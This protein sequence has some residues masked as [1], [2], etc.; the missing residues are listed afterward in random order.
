MHHEEQFCEIILNLAQW[1]RRI[2]HLKD[3]FYGALAVLQ[4]G[5]A[6]NIIAILRES[7]M[8]NIHVKLYGIWTSGSEGNV[9]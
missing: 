9:V 5:G 3:F 2:C 4:F 8:G 7:S 1:S 6:K